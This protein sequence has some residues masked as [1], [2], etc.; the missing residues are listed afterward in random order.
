MSVIPAGVEGLDL[1]ICKLLLTEVQD[2]V[3]GEYVM[4][5]RNYKEVGLILGMTEN[6]VE[7]RVRKLRKRLRA[8]REAARPTAK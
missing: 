2:Q 8:E 4:R 6:A 1:T 3:N 7:I 5:L